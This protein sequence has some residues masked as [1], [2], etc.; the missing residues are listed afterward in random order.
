MK[1][2]IFFPALIASFGLLVSS[3]SFAANTT[4]NQSKDASSSPLSSSVL[5]NS[6]ENSMTPNQKAVIE[7]VVHDYLVQHPEVL[8]EAARALQA[9]QAKQVEV[10][11]VSAIE[12]NKSA[13]FENAK[14]PVGGNESGKIYLVEFF[15][16]QCSHCK[17][18]EPIVEG[19]LKNN[20][21]I[22]V[23]Y[24]ELP[25]FGGNSEYAAKAALASAKQGKY[26][27]FHRA[28]YASK[29]PLTSDNVLKIAKSV[30]IDTDQLNKD[31]QDPA[32]DQQI[33]ENFAL[34]E[35]LRLVGT[36]TFVIANPDL[37]VFSFIPGAT[38]KEDL[39]ARI[40]QLSKTKDNNS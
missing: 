32:M 23:I 12:K 36:P 31:M 6:T 16:Y 3:N 5:A 30:G 13:L 40:N 29:D 11:A 18:M 37:T 25:I 10:Q 28:L 39:E 8:M 19:V 21:D 22:R 15:D 14:S 1:L 38:T 24:K 20:N 33:K 7:K 2:K 9:K 34:A 26:E 35:K 17:E 4:E 27:Q